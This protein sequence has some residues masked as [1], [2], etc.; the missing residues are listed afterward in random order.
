MTTG[1]AVTTL[2]SMVTK[3]SSSFQV[4]PTVSS[5]VGNYEFQVGVV[6]PYAQVQPIVV[7]CKFYI[8]VFDCPSA[9]FVLDA[10][11]T[12]NLTVEL[13]VSQTWLITVI[14]SETVTDCSSLSVN[15]VSD[16]SEIFGS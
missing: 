7:S 15:L 12:E 11:T 8:R 13:F 2:P 1:S 3:Q 10:S 16:G 14:S 6:V 9:T 5:D 4:S